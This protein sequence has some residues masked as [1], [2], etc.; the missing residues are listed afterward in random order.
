MTNLPQDKPQNFTDRDVR[1]FFDKYFKERLSFSASKVDSVIGFFE[2]RGFDK[3]SAIAVGTALLEQS[4]IDNVNVYQLLDTLKGLEE[5]QLSAVV[6]EILN[7][8]R[9]KT[10]SL[11]YRKRNHFDKA[12]VRNIEQPPTTTSVSINTASEN[13]VTKGYVA[14]GYVS[15]NK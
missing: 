13:Y 7:Y 10:S 2:K 14:E 15:S 11:G 8:S 1:E 12:E 5:V 6:T 4:K 9:P 3:S